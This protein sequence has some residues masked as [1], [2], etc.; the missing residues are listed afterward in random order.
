MLGRWKIEYCSKKLNDKIDLSNEDHC[1]QGRMKSS[2]QL[3]TE[4]T[5]S[6]LCSLGPCGNYAIDKNIETTKTTKTT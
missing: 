3:T 5:F 2:Q 1:G 4:S 6:A